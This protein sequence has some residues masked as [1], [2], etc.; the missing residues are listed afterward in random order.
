M[1]RY[2]ENLDRTK[3]P[4]AWRILRMA[5]LTVGGIALA[6]L[7]AL[8]LGVVVQWLWNWLI[9]DIFGLKTIS[10][11]QA[12]GLLFLGRLL[13]GTLGHHGHPHGHHPSRRGWRSGRHESRKNSGHFRQEE[14]DEPAAESPSAVSQSN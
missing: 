2:N 10:Y 1:K 3:T 7:F 9:P 6:A 8:V 11:W 13:F 14:E 5:G 12:F 4:I